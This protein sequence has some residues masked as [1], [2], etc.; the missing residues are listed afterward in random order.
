MTTITQNSSHVSP[1]PA[2]PNSYDVLRDTNNNNNPNTTTQQSTNVQDEVTLVTGNLKPKRS[3]R[4]FY[5][6]LFLVCAVI[7][8]ILVLAKKRFPLLKFVK[9]VQD[10]QGV[11]GLC[12]ILVLTVWIVVCLPSTIPEV[13]CG[14]LF[15][16]PWAICFGT[17][18]KGLGNYI[19]F[20]IARSISS[21][22]VEECLQGSTFA[23]LRGLHTAMIAQPYKMCFLIRLVFIPISVKNYGMGLLPCTHLQF[24]VTSIATGIP[25]TVL[26]CVIGQ[27]ADQVTQILDQNNN[28]PGEG[29]GKI[30]KHNFVTE[31]VLLCVGALSMVAFLAFLGYYSKKEWSKVQ[32]Q[33]A[34]AIDERIRADEEHGKVRLR[35]HSEVSSIA[36]FGPSVTLTIVP[37]TPEFSAGVLSVSPPP[38]SLLEDGN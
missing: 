35:D 32:Q 17:V 8:G 3:W 29:G 36:Y 2:Q 9:W 11:G 6:K 27:S 25:F 12:F 1:K 4:K 14:F 33:Q 23:I 28:T 37:P 24:I 38:H 21:S 16:L 22:R 19:S 15:P 26:W 10:H 30:L 18:G 5:C 7:I 20:L 13:L 31:M 34:A